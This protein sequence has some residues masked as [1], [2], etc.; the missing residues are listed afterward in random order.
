M[1]AFIMQNILL[2]YFTPALNFNDQTL[3]LITELIFLWRFENI[4]MST[5]TVI[6]CV[7]GFYQKEFLFKKEISVNV[8]DRF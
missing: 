4:G 5:V 1:I 8:F 6:S 3:W 7:H 2:P